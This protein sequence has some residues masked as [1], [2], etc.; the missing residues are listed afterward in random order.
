MMTPKQNRGAGKHRAPAVPLDYYDKRY[1]SR[2]T[3]LFFVFHHGEVTEQG[4]FDSASR[5]LIRDENARSRFWR[6]KFVNGTPQQVV[7][8]A[9]SQVCEKAT[10][11]NSDNDDQDVVW[12]VFDRDSFNDYPGAITSAEEYGMKVAYSNECFELWLLLYFQEVN[13]HHSRGKLAEMLRGRWEELS[14]VI[15]ETPK[16]VKHFPYG[17]IHKYGSLENA[18]ARA[19]I[20][21]DKAILAQ[22][23]TPWNVSP[24]TTVYKL[25][26][27]LQEFFNDLTDTS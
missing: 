10:D 15:V 11:T 7:E 22:P 14:G 3:S 26:E 5:N 20:L 13:E 24:V 23:D 18:V 9:Y 27:H 17:L 21:Y 2:K 25:I 4:Y 6:L 16:Q 8:N 12:I 19:K 1:G